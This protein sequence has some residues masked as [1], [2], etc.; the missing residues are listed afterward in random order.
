MFYFISTYIVHEMDV[1]VFLLSTPVATII[2]TKREQTSAPIW[3]HI[4]T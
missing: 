2:D 4:S 3:L 1:W